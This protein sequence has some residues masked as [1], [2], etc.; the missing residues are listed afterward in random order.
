MD[1]NICRFFP[2]GYIHAASFDEIVL[3]Y[4]SSLRRLGASVRV[5]ANSLGASGVNLVFGAHLMTDDQARLLPDTVIVC[6][7]EQVDDDSIWMRS[8]GLKSLLT[9]CEVWDYSKRN[10]EILRQKTGNTKIRW[11]PVG[12]VP[13]LTKIVPADNQDIDVLFYGSIN[14][15]RRNII[16]ELNAAELN[17]V[18]VFGVYGVERDSLISRA[19]VVLNLHYYE[20]GVFELVRVSYLLA[21]RKA[22]VSEVR[23]LKDVPH[24]IRRSVFFSDYRMIA[25][26]CRFL[27][28]EED[29]RKRLEI[30]AIDGVSKLSMEKFLRPMLDNKNQII[31]AG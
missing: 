18:S 14:D 25:D 30:L 27:V 23:D 7:F 11:V 8:Q 31:L 16:N 4:Q 13:E 2:V 10:A 12:Y 15:R 24:E 29:A 1:F 9:R 28:S 17:V 6:N 22:V 20:L 26:S 3:C 19:K 21:N 5:F